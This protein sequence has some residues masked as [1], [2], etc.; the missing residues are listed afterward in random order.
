MYKNAYCEKTD[1]YVDKMSYCEETD[2]YVYK[3]SPRSSL[4]INPSPTFL[5]PP[6]FDSMLAK[7]ISK[8]HFFSSPIKLKLDNKI[9]YCEETD[10]YLYKNA[11]C[12]KTDIYV[13]KIS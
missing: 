2:F 9:S 6:K 10:I 8:G 1:I 11:Y 13:D 5:H 7:R 4:W 3:I 12:E